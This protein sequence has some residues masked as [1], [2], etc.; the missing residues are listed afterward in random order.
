[1]LELES[2][3][4]IAQLR[5]SNN[6][7]DL[8]TEQELA[9]I[10][11]Q[12]YR[13]YEI[14]EASR[15]G[16]KEVV[17]QAMEIAKQIMQKK[18][19]PWENASNIKFPLIAQASIDYASRTM[20]EVIQNGKVVKAIVVGKD[21]DNMKYDRASRIS[22]F[23]SYQLIEQS[24]GW[25]DGTDLLLQ[26]LP[27]LG[28]AFKKTYYDEVEK[29]NCS[30]MCVP[31]K[32]VIN[33]DTQSIEKAPR[34]THILT[35]YNNDIIQNQRLKL[36]V[37]C[38]PCLLE[39][40]HQEDED[41]GKE[42]LEQ[43]TYLDLDDDGYKEPYIVTIHRQSKK[44]MRIVSRFKSI[45]K[46]SDGDI[47][48]IE[49]IQYFTDFHF[50]RSPD[51]GFYSMGFGSLLLPINKAIN[52]LI[53]QLIDSGTLNIM[54]GG[55]IGRGLRM[56]NGSIRFKM[57]EWQVLDAASGDDIRKNIFPWPTKEPSGTLYSLLGLL[58]QVGKDLSSTTD[59]L[60]GKQ[61]AQNVAT[62]TIEQLVEQGTKVFVA[63]NKRLYRSLKKEYRKLYDLNS[64]YLSQAEYSNIMDD[65]NALVKVDFHVEGLDVIPV[66]DPT[67][68]TETQRIARA[69]ALQQLRT[70]DP[71]EADKLLLE[72][73]QLDTDVI[74][75]L[76]P[77][78][79]PNAPPPPETQ[80][81]MAEIAFIQAQVANLSAQATLL[82]EK[83]A[84]EQAKAQQDLKESDSRIDEA[85][86]RA[87]KMQQDALHNIKKNAIVEAKMNSEQQMKAIDLIHKVDNEQAKTI[88]EA[89]K[90]T[91]DSELQHKKLSQDKEAAKNNKA[92]SYSEADI[93]HTA[94]LKNMSVKQ[95][96]EKLGIVQ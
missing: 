7:A 64:K 17:D 54:Q 93:K 94:K 73:M 18:S 34:I 46:N 14:D 75:K 86:A 60:S 40:I 69:G 79:D 6:I 70:A 62:G 22:Q 39:D 58:M 32:I 1:M 29:C 63:I 68:S 72:A 8:L 85:V 36:F 27:V 3:L 37:D 83:N 71:R 16:W 66:A 12:V 50:I 2:K 87:W 49:P 21:K 42:F 44:V 19:F 52:T 89:N 95:V 24:M 90:V 55:I 88:I 48:K 53:N 56:K 61:P 13:G 74:E 25:E 35:L 92:K 82:A 9:E 80:K 41:S 23:M 91:Q 57:G 51:G 28:T 81:I 33:Y 84:L 59:V 10:G 67:V 30:E 5:K 38:D 47:V 20:P 31:D 11:Q 43:H 4:N 76:L 77:Q 26:V 78:Q 45:K 96:K 15:S 65:E